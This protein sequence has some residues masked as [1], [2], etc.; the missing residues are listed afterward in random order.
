[1]YKLTATERKYIGRLLK[2]APNKATQIEVMGS[3]DEDD[4][5]NL[6][7]Q[8]GAVESYKDKEEGRRWDAPYG[9]IGRR[10][11]RRVKNH[12]HDLICGSS[13]AYEQERRKLRTQGEGLVMI[14]VPMIV[15]AL[16]L[17]PAAVGVAIL[18]ALIVA[19]VGVRAFCEEFQPT[20]A[21]RDVVRRSRKAKNGAER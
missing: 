20:A 18:L 21:S 12:L 14:L 10:Y 19:K 8:L 5:D 7:F 4:F 11:W 15:S 6:V 1:M 2:Q 16:N 13:K 9:T 3:I 17:P